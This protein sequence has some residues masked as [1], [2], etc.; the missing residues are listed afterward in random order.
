MRWFKLL[1]SKREMQIDSKPRLR[2]VEK[3]TFVVIPSATGVS[4][5]ITLPA[6]A[7]WGGICFL[8]AA[9]G[10]MGAFTLKYFELRTAADEYAA[11]KREHESMR[12]EATALYTQLRDVQSNLNQVDNFSDQVRQA[13][14]VEEIEQPKLRT[15]K[16]P[17]QNKK[18]KSPNKQPRQG[19]LKP[20][21][22]SL[23]FVNKLGTLSTELSQEFN[24]SI[25]A[26]EGIG[27]V[28]KEEYEKHLQTGTTPQNLAVAA[29]VKPSSLQF[30]NVFHEL[31]ALRKQSSEQIDDLT[32]LLAEVQQYRIRVDQTPTISP[33]EGRLTSHFG[34][35]ESPI[36][37]QIR[38]HRGLDIAAPMGSPIRAAAAGV[39]LRTGRA[40]DY[41]RYVEISHGHSVVTVYAHAQ[42]I[43]VK[44]GDQVHKGQKIALVGMSGRTTGP[45]LHYEVR[46]GNDRVNPFNYISFNK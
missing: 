30:E 43:L 12:S 2:Q 7:V 9:F 44:K 38:M 32:S 28:S 16:K 34:Y 23:R 22:Q 19:Y 10:A 27:P 13:T 37:G 17:D 35:R 11:L 21:D 18:E 46:V 24:L 20:A 1:R 15:D 45:H 26:L 5:K 8:T 41:G 36:D 31:N 3:I 33:V 25:P 40:A 42:Q 39:V 6:A 14:K 4:R 29:K